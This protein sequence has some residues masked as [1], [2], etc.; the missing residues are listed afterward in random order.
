[1]IPANRPPPGEQSK[2]ERWSL[3]YF[4]RPGDSVLLNALVDESPAIAG[5]VARRPG[6]NFKTGTTSYEWFSRRIKY[7]RIK[8]RKVCVYRSEWISLVRIEFS[9]P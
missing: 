5:A 8:N 7:Q 9:G 6:K 4:T 3:V 1:M 2:Y